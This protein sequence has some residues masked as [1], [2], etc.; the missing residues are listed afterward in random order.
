MKILQ[1]KGN[2]TFIQEEIKAGKIFIYPTDTLY[3]LGCDATNEEAVQKI[4][5][6][7]NRDEKPFLIIAPNLDWIKTN[8]EFNHK[9]E[10]NKLPGPYSFIVKPKPNIVAK[11][12]LANKTTLGVRIPNSEFTQFLIKPFVSTSVNMAGEPSAINLEEI[13]QEIKFQ[14]DYILTTTKPLLGKPSTIIDLTQ[15]KPIQLR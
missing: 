4:R 15:E 13:P 7:K 3:G 5:K 9:E 6:I 2:E 1:I 12:V 14:V 10:L 11:S 8:C